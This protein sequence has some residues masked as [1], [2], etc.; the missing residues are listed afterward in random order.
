MKMVVDLFLIHQCVKDLGTPFTE[1]KAYK[2]GTIDEYGN[3]LKE[4]HGLSEFEVMTSRVKRLSESV[5][6]SR[7]NVT[8]YAAVFCLMK[9]FSDI[10]T[11]GTITDE[12]ILES[13]EKW[14]DYVSQNLHL[15]EE[16][17]ANSAGSGAIAGIGVGPSKKAEPGFTK[18]QMRK[19]K[20]KN[21]IL[22]RKRPGK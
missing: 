6:G 22:K 13:L 10:N 16:V 18:G 5:R 4:N 3:I 8:S 21:N 9:E 12:E 14:N 17:P 2:T 7:S 1:W 20:K 15:V 11:T 19:Y